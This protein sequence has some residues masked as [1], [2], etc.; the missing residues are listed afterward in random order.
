MAVHRPLLI[1]PVLLLALGNVALAAGTYCLKCHR[2]HYQTIGSC[3]DCHRGDPRSDR[4][5]IAHHD[6]VQGRYSWFAVPGAAPV[7]RGYRLMEIFA[8]RRCHISERK[9]N[10][11]ASDLDH[12]PQGTAAQAISDSIKNPALLMPQFHLADTDRVYLVNAIL[13]GARRAR[14]IGEGRAEVPQVVHFQKEQRDRSNVFETRCGPCHRMLTRFWGGLGRGNIAPNLSGLFTEFYPQTA[15]EMKGESTTG[16]LTDE[17]MCLDVARTRTKPLVGATERGVWTPLHLGK[18][19]KNPRLF[20]ENSQMRP[21]ALER[22]EFESLVANF[23][24]E[25]SR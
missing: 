9:G 18:W 14:V 13:A 19:L 5:R 22:G 20:R 1:V 15:K 12:L 4:R 17:G 7:A 6:L 21:V 2:P 16:A 10:R 11:L 25:A 8:C 24:M 3:V 23:K